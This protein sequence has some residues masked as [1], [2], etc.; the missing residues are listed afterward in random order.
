MKAIT[1]ANKH[2]N[3]YIESDIPEKMM[4]TVLALKQ[5]LIE[6]AAEADDELLAKY[7]D[8]EVLSDEEIKIG[9][10]KGISQAKIFPVL[11]GSAYKNIGIQ[12][13]ME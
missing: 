7:L 5:N 10:C 8:G 1:P 9:L 4:E 11:C 12:Q 2:G 13:I 3:Q 6:S